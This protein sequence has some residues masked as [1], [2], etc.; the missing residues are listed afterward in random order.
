M[1]LTSAVVFGISIDRFDCFSR[2]IGRE[3]IEHE[4]KRD[5]KGNY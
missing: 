2:S 1:T 3:A 4:K 5:I